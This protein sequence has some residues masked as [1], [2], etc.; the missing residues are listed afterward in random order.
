MSTGL[1]SWF[2]AVAASAVMLFLGMRLR[3]LSPPELRV[4]CGAC[5]RLV[6]RRSTCPCSRAKAD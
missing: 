3:L 4:R 5:G 1:A 2:P 6:L